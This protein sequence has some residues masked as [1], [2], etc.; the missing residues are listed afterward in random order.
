MQGDGEEG[1]PRF[2]AAL[3]MSPLTSPETGRKIG[4]ILLTAQEY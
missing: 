4:Q 2:D 1:K 3:T